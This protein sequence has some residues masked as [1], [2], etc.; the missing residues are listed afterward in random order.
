MREITWIF[1]YEA[2]WTSSDFYFKP[3]GEQ[4]KQPQGGVSA[5]NFHIEHGH[6][7]LGAVKQWEGGMANLFTTSI[8]ESKP[9][10]PQKT[11]R[12]F[13]IKHIL[14]GR[15]ENTDVNRQFW[16]ENVPTA[17]SKKSIQTLQKS[18]TFLSSRNEALSKSTD[19]EN[20]KIQR[21]TWWLIIQDI[22]DV[23]CFTQTNLQE[24]GPPGLF[25]IIQQTAVT[26]R[27][28]GSENGFLLRA[29]QQRLRTYNQSA[30]TWSNWR[31]QPASHL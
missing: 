14:Q 20:V 23:S 21:S 12:K 18:Q 26:E 7:T 10:P 4:Y 19:Y 15:P 27:S 2:L 28:E 30:T 13:K 9:L 8:S 6:G 29:V 31:H 17:P 3:E 1:L 24:D 22:T 16:Q 25:I 11:K 5:T